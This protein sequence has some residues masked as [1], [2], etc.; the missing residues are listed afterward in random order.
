MNK[1]QNWQTKSHFEA[2]A[3][4]EKADA[5]ALAE[6]HIK[7]MLQGAARDRIV[8]MTPAAG[9]AGVNVRTVT[10][11]QQNA[12]MPTKATP[13]TVNGD[14]LATKPTKPAIMGTKKPVTVTGG[15]PLMAGADRS[16]E[17][18]KPLDSG[19]I[20]PAFHAMSHLPK[21]DHPAAI[22]LLEQHGISVGIK[23]GILVI[24]RKYVVAATGLL[25]TFA[26]GQ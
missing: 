10:A 18:A 12:A 16:R 2:L 17:A 20:G 1:L 4:V 6:Q 22:Q 8:K 19:E 14:G 23:D 25:Q 7:K 11:V 5:E 3:K 9:D 26:G 13:Q 15:S 21:G 24:Q